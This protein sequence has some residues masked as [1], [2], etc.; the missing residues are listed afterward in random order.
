M[1]KYA[2][3][4]IGLHRRA[5]K[6]W[7]VELRFNHPE[8][9]ADQI[10]APGDSRVRIDL[11]KLQE[12]VF[13]P[14]AYG[15]VLSKSLFAPQVERAFNIARTLAQSDDL[16]LRVRLR[17][18]PSAPELH[19][20]WWET[21]RDPKD[22]S[23]LLM[24]YSILFSR[25]LSSL[26]WRPVGI[27]PKSELR[28][29]AVIANPSDLSEFEADRRSLPAIDVVEELN[30]AKH[31]MG[32]T[33]VTA[34]AS[35]GRATLARV[36]SELRN[37]HDILYLVCHGY[38]VDGEPQILL[39]DSSARAHRVAGVEFVDALRD[40]ERPPRLV[41]LVSCHTAGLGEETSSDHHGA[42]AALG[43]R[44]AEA[45]I[46]AVL[47][48]QGRVS[49]ATMEQFIPVFFEE[50]HRDGQIDRAMTVA[51]RAV[52]DRHDWWVPV[53]FMRLKTG[54]FWYAP[55][56]TGQG[57]DFEKWPA[58]LND[59]RHERC[60][61]VL[62]PA[63][64]DGLIGSRQ[65]IAQ[66]WASQYHFP[67]APHQREDLPHVAQYLAVNLSP[68]FPRDE[69]KDYY[70]RE[71]LK[72]YGKHLPPGTKEWPLDELLKAVG[73]YRRS[74]DQ[75]EPHAVLARL[76]FKI[77]ITAHV[78]DLF[79]DALRAEGKDPQPEL[80][81]WKDEPIWPTS[82]FDDPTCQYE[83]SPQQ[84]LVYHLFGHFQEP[85][86]LVLTEDD[87]FD[88]L[89]G[90]TKNKELIPETVRR[91]LADSALLFLGFRMDEW[92]FRVLFRSILSQQANR[93]KR[94][95]HIAAQIDPEEGRMIE[96][97]RARRYLESYFSQLDLRISIFWGSVENFVRRLSA[98]WQEDEG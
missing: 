60:T 59:I 84:P 61:P 92:N 10:L 65:E 75:F 4:E 1:V 33:P 42:L 47:A 88:Y 70:H 11:G 19:G 58:L 76:P 45:G 25:Y 97:D 69:L 62:G 63:L 28:A 48:M 30:R 12:H 64:N 54:R 50:L 78:S 3:L 26:D 83:P 72:R 93:W 81:R 7:S 13:D 15:R 56:F 20:V 34:L 87:Y 77:F 24:D 14:S 38:F 68:Q 98:L 71:L 36:A 79:T 86:T 66:G 37:G 55:G 80:C 51:R 90:V 57:R 82:I 29:L 2:D 9:A 31:A 40:L 27:R 39:E 43:P 53:L 16:P 21:L 5:A 85:D 89:I 73:A 96:P 18:D 41:V 35:G 67:M 8:S 32:R 52:R 17:I 94:Y 46:P 74:V 44:M 22:G 95:T 6:T 91:A 23:A 49:M